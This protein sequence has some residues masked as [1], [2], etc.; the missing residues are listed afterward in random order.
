MVTWPGR[1]SDMDLSISSYGV[2]IDIAG[3]IHGGGK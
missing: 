2:P 3:E 1:N